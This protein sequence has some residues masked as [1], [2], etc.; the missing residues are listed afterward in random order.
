MKEFLEK[1]KT[2]LKER[3]DE[4]TNQFTY[5]NVLRESIRYT[6]LNYGKLF[7]PLLTM[8]VLHDLV[9]DPSVGFDAACA[10]ELLHNY[11][12]IHDDLP[13]MDDDHHRRGKLCNH[14]V[15][16]EAQAILAGDALQAEAFKLLAT[17]KVDDHIK[18]ELITYVA[19]MVGANGLVGGQSL[20]IINSNE[21][22]EDVDLEQLNKIHF[23]KTG[24]LIE[25]AMLAGA[26]IGKANAETIV[27]I[28]DIA[29]HVGLAFQIRDD[30]IDL[31]VPN[32]Q[33]GKDM[34]SDIKND[35][36]TYPKVY[37]LEKSK[38]ILAEH[39]ASALEGAKEVF[40]AKSY[41]YQFI[42]EGLK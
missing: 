21:S 13:A 30:I 3:L 15:Y 9:E 11:G 23:G 37:G 38:V 16:G 24:G 10:I 5:S 36:L 20:D 1:W 34:K 26:I 4:I 2:L 27:K 18:V 19:D 33:S 41:T 7:R 40:G 6:V 35:K 31:E 39:R 28:K 17:L 22:K 14:L 25:A 12:L 42:E 32:E 29:Y 8:V